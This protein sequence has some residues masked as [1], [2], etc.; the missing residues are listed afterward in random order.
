MPR[1][2]SATSRGSARAAPL[3]ANTVAVRSARRAANLAR[4][5]L[6][7]ARLSG[8]MGEYRR[9]L[10]V[11]RNSCPVPIHAQPRDITPV[12]GTGL[13]PA[14]LAVPEPKSG[15]SAI[16]P[17]SRDRRRLRVVARPRVCRARNA[18]SRLGLPPAPCGPSFAADAAVFASAYV[19][20]APGGDGR[21]DVLRALLRSGSSL[22][23]CDQRQEVGRCW[24]I[25]RGPS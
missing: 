25:A 23:E 16:P 20:E 21:A 2:A 24:G 7:P 17:S 12:R 13:E 8:V 14:H 6:S 22:L 1:A 15:A 4:S 3:H 10:R 11:H 18:L 9:I 19:H 5:L